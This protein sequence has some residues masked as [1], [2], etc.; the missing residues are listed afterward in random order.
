MKVVLDTNVLISGIF[1]GGLPR[2]VLDAWAAERFELLVSPSIFDEYVRTC[3][4][5]SASHEGLQYQSVLAS[6]NGHGTLEPDSLSTGPITADPE[7]DKFML[8]ALG[9]GAIIVSGD[10]HLLD[11]SS[12][13]GVR[14]MMP[15]D[16]LEYL[17]NPDAT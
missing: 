8:C 17:D 3:D 10:Q 13:E 14:V 4:R 2:T 1:F 5:L 6:I 9:H 7:D 11:A 15:N 12:W 16:F